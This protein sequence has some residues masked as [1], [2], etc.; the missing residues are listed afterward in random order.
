MKRCGHKLN[1]QSPKSPAQDLRRIRTIGSLIRSHI[2]GHCG[3]GHQSHPGTSNIRRIINP[4]E[5]QSK[6]SC[7]AKLIRRNPS[8]GFSS[9][10]TMGFGWMPP[11]PFAS[12]RR[13]HLPPLASPPARPWD[14]DGCP[15]AV[16]V[17]QTSTLPCKNAGI[18][19]GISITAPFRISSRMASWKH[20]SRSQ[21]RY[22]PAQES[23]SRKQGY[24]HSFDCSVSEQT[25]L[26]QS[27]W[28][29]LKVSPLRET[30]PG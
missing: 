9:C 13:R 2:P 5:P 22:Q 19:A 14:L 6:L 16:R 26:L 1:G 21:Q 27:L 28:L 8:I 23:A 15:L 30:P 29:K 20:W 18:T 7:V 24:M 11:S 25:D 3:W 17:S 10:T 12:V 4:V